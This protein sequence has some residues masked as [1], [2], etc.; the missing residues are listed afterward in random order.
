MHSTFLLLRTQQDKFG[1]NYECRFFYSFFYL[2]F[3]VLK[4]KKKNVENFTSV[5]FLFFLFFFCTQ[6]EKKNSNISPPKLCPIIFFFFIL[7]HNITSYHAPLSA[8]GSVRPK[9]APSTS[10]A[11]MSVSIK[12]RQVQSGTCPSSPERHVCFLLVYTSYCVLQALSILLLT[13]CFQAYE[14]SF[15]AVI[16]R[17][18]TTAVYH[19]SQVPKAN[20]T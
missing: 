17:D 9:T 6:E 13:T 20:A 5:H 18:G 16:F 1:T 19:I 15:K 11:G 12:R 14:Q 8:C 7:S 2:H 4:K 10:H 3:K